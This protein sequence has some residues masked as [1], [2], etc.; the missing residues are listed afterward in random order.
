MVAIGHSGAADPTVMAAS[1]PPGFGQLYGGD[2]DAPARTARTAE[3]GGHPFPAPDS[4][5]YYDTR[6]PGKTKDMDMCRTVL[7]H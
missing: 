6:N 4:G 1:G 3:H 5:E 7:M 2:T